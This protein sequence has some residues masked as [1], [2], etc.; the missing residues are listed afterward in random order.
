MRI[1]YD[2]EYMQYR[3]LEVL[4]DI[5]NLII[6]Y[7]KV[8]SSLTLYQTRT[9]NYPTHPNLKVFPYK[10]LG[11]PYRRVSYW[12]EK[13]ISKLLIFLIA[14]IFVHLLTMNYLTGKNLTN[15]AVLL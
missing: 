12:L 10:R 13:H 14:L 5:L 7:Q 4:I 2:G 6:G 3:L 15:I 1:L 8:Y 9:L 11:F